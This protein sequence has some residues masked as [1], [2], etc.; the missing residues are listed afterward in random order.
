MN[1]P[2]SVVTVTLGVP[3]LGQL[4]R[5]VKPLGVNWTVPSSQLQVTFLFIAEL[6]LTV[7]VNVIGEIW[8]AGRN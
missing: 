7:A 5:Q 3:K 1:P 2:S 6:G 4:T 8:F